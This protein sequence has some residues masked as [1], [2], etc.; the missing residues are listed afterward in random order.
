MRIVRLVFAFVSSVAA[1]VIVV[2]FSLQNG[3]LVPLNFF[4]FQ[5]QPIPLWSVIIGA[6]CVGALTAI[7]Y[8]FEELWYL[9][10]RCRLLEK[11]LRGKE[12]SGEEKRGEPDTIED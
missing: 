2:I 9:S 4:K 10:K 6:F 12:G 8:C 1:L 3:Q 7:I 11:K 5:T